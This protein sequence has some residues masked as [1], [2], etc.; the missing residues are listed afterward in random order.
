MDDTQDKF[1]LVEEPWPVQG[2]DEVLFAAV[3]QHF[4]IQYF[5]FKGYNEKSLRILS[6]AAEQS[7]RGL[8][9]PQDQD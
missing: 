3:S 7:V 1:W 6:S 2:K 9:T 5:L 4:L 8:E